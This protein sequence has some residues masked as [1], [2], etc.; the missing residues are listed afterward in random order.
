M[1]VL[2]SNLPAAAALKNSTTP[3]AY[4]ATGNDASHDDAPA[5]EAAIAAMVAACIADGSYVCEV[6]FDSSKNYYANRAPVVNPTINGTS[7]YAYAQIALPYLPWGWAAPNATPIVTLILR[8]QSSAQA[9][10]TSF[11]RQP[12]SIITTPTTGAGW[13]SGKGIPSVI[14]G[15]AFKGTSP[16]TQ[17][18]GINLVVDG[19]NISSA[20]NPVFCGLDLTTVNTCD[21]WTLHV[22]V[23]TNGYAAPTACTNIDAFGVRFP[24]NQNGGKIRVGTL[25]VYGYYT[26]IAMC[27]HLIADNIM[28]Y[29]NQLAI[30]YDQNADHESHISVLQTSG[31]QN[32]IAFLD[33]N[34]GIKQVPSSLGK[35]APLVVDQWGLEDIS[36]KIWDLNNV[37]NIRATIYGVPVGG[38]TNVVPPMDGGAKVRLESMIQ[39]LGPV[40]TAP[41]IPATT[42]AY[43]NVYGHDAWVVVTGGTVT[44]IAVNGTATGL[45]A[46]QILVPCGGSI[47]LTYSVAPTWAWWLF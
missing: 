29:W 13:V 41:A 20:A 44:G 47:T 31:N 40:A 34:L 2:G 15:P 26:G 22:T 39:P 43:Q 33:Y 35:P 25:A 6:V 10:N 36:K 38:T 9:A 46:G 12:C 42:V 4:G 28:L 14:G 32:L 7:S 45:T 23:P 19:L 27:E 8:S 3:E 18:S 1:P 30:S 21:I 24:A 16:P 37:L 11:N 5:I 17:W